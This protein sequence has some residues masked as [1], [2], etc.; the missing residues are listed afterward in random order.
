M[1]PA[2]PSRVAVALRNNCAPYHETGENRQPRCS[3]QFINNSHGITPACDKQHR[4]SE[5]NLAASNERQITTNSKPQITP[6]S[7]RQIAPSSR[8]QIV[9]NS[10]LQIVPNSR[11]QVAPNSRGDIVAAPVTINHGSAIGNRLYPAIL[12]FSDRE[13]VV[14]WNTTVRQSG[15]GSIL[16]YY[17]SPIGITV[18][19]GILRFPGRDW[20]DLVEND[21]HLYDPSRTL[22][23]PLAG[24]NFFLI[25]L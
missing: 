7:R 20:G 15:L 25:R 24:P 14:S 6:S 11:H 3:L 22:D 9:A 8:L 1:S 5:H 21:S 10:R 12:R 4:A 17:T 18:Y 23:T 13:C 16:E 19:P 2:K